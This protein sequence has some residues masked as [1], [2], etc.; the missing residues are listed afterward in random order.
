MEGGGKV[1][2]EGHVGGGKAL[3]VDEE[4]LEVAL[5]GGEAVLEGGDVVVEAGV[6]GRSSGEGMGRKAVAAAGHGKRR[7]LL[8]GW[9]MG[10]VF[11]EGFLH[12]F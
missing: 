6:G 7:V 2:F 10:F 12:I 11:V 9:A 3:V 8:L 4:G 5:L 1:L